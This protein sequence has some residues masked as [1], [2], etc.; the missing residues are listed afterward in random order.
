MTHYRNS[1]I[2]TIRIIKYPYFL[3]CKFFLKIFSNL[4]FQKDATKI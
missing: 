3:Y 1:L 2:F 4:S